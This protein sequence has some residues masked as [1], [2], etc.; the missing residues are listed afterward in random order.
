[1]VKRTGRAIF[2]VALIFVTITAS[3]GLVGQGAQASEITSSPTADRRPASALPVGTAN[4][5]RLLLGIWQPGVPYDLSSL[6]SIEN[7]LNARFDIVTWYQG[8]GA[9]NK[10]LDLSQLQAVSQRG[11]IP[12]IT[13]E[14]WDYT[15]GTSQPKFRMYRII[16]GK[17][18]SYIRSWA[19]GLKRY[20]KPV[21]LRF[22]HEMN[23]PQYPWSIGVNKT[24][25]RNYKKAWR[26]IHDIFSDVGATNVIWVWSP[27]VEYAGTTPFRRIYPGD[28]YVDWVALDGYNAGTALDWGGWIDFAQIFRS[29]YRKL[30]W[31]T[32][33]PIMIA[34]VG[35]A[36]QGGNKAAWITNALTV[37]LPNKFPRIEALIWFNENREA[38]WR[39]NSSDASAEAF[40]RV[41]NQL[42]R[43]S[44]NPKLS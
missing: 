34:E 42:G 12:F 10:N 16:N 9:A 3:L 28:K 23:H 39:I 14:P 18:D 5:S 19:R 2:A 27:N 29:S 20:G 6:S 32:D 31:L 37:Q 24:N 41:L 8:W 1:M 26:H 30:T 11:A 33:K 17:F 40:S 4:S 7:Q 21:F 13:W 25:A 15:Q 36:E 22:A 38:D 44:V 35:A 43:N